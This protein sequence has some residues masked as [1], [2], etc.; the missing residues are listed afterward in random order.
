MFVGLL[1]SF[2][3]KIC[4]APCIW[5]GMRNSESM[6]VSLCR[7]MTLPIRQVT[8]FWPAPYNE[9]LSGPSLWK[10]CGDNHK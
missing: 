8:S 10:D 1:L 9:G 4:Y 3:T 5:H 7:M 6:A 2:L